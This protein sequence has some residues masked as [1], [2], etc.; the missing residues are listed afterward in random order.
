MKDVSRYT[1]TK[2]IVARLYFGMDHLKELESGS[3]Q[4]FQLS[5]SF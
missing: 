3:I 5:S 2:K 4:L 1:I